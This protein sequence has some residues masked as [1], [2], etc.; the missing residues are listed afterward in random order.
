[1]LADELVQA[2]LR[3]RAVAVD[4]GPVGLAGWLSLDV[5]NR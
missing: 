3:D 4:V 1:M 5:S 2:L